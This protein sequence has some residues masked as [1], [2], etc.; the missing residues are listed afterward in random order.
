[1]VSWLLQTPLSLHTASASPHEVILV[2]STVDATIT[3]GRPRGIIVDS[4]YDRDPLDEALQ[5][6]GIEM[7]APHKSYRLCAISNYNEKTS[8]IYETASTNMAG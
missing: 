1:M 3:L 8:T 4:A 6:Q 7:I 2:Q 5:V